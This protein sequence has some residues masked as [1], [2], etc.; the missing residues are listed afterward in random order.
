MDDGLRVKYFVGWGCGCGV[1]DCVWSPTHSVPLSA[2]L[3][4]VLRATH[5]NYF[6]LLKYVRAI[7]EVVELNL[8]Y[9]MED[10]TIWS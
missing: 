9:H 1:G 4:S 2:P 8:K 5:G 7:Q 10:R 6:E 3:S